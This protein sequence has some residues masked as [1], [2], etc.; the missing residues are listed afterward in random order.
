MGKAAEGM[1]FQE[2][3][4]AF[5]EE[6]GH[7]ESRGSNDA[8]D[9]KSILWKDSE[10]EG[11]IPEIRNFWLNSELGRNH[12]RFYDLDGEAI[13]MAGAFFWSDH[14]ALASLAARIRKTKALP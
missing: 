6:K 8:T 7:L 3:S 13:S 2:A 10:Q 11:F 14:D 1:Q 9:R 4:L 5:F 12:A